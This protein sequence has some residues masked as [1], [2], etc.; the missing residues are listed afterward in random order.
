MLE[1]TLSRYGD[2][3]LPVGLLVVALG[4]LAMT[5]PQGGPAAAALEVVAA[6]LLV[7]RRRYGVLAPTA[8]AVTLLQ[9]PWMGPALDDLAAPI[10]FCAAVGY[11]LGRWPAGN[12]GLAGLAVVLATFWVDYRFVDTRQHGVGDVIFVL[13]LIAPPYVLGRLMQR[14]AQ[15][16]TLLEQSQEAARR[17]AVRAERDRIAR[18]LHDVIAHSVSAMVVQTAAAQDLVRRDPDRA[19][20]LLAAVAATGRQALADT[21]RLL[22]VVRDEADE[23]GLAPIPGL[24]DLPAL[25]DRFRGDG[26]EVTAD[27]DLPLVGLP[28]GVDVSAYR[29][30]QE[31]LTNALR[32]GADRTAEITIACSPEAVT[33]RASNPS[34]GTGGLGSGLGL[35]GIAERV[36]LLGGTL[37]HGLADDGRFH[38][39]AVLPLAPVER[40]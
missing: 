1:R 35:L 8:S 25:V 30:A 20:Q 27:L 9:I 36:S 38:L 11:A 7:R 37:W 39:D 40:T 2:L 26:L 16:K 17:A 3:L 24:A 14:L 32:Y 29:I 23:L 13:T 4:E 10:L 15:Q 6:A 28:A 22:H 33:I 5:R 19:E 21:G 34:S 18:E 31:A 12:R